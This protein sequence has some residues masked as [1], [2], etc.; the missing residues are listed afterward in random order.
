[1]SYCGAKDQKYPDKNSM[2]FPFDRVIKAR[3]I[4]EFS[5]PNMKFQDVKIQFKE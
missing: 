5:S 1:V 2:G 3:T 4:A